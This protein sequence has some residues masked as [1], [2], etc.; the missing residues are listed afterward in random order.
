MY[1]TFFDWTELILENTKTPKRKMSR[2]TGNSV[3]KGGK[4]IL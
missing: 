3:L 1:V 4:W 2:I